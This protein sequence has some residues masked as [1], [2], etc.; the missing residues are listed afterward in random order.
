MKENEKDAEIENEELKNIISA[1]D[2]V[3]ENTALL[4]NIKSETELE[5]VM[6]VLL[7]SLGKYAGADRSYIFELKPDSTKILHMTHV[8][9]ADGISP[10]FR[11][12]QDLPLSTVPN[13]FSI[14]NTDGAVVIY[15]WD[16]D[17]EKWPEEYQLFSGQGIKS[18][19]I[20]PLVSGGSVTGYMGVDNPERNR[21]ELSVSLL[22]GI[23]GHISGL[24]ENLYMMKRLEENQLSLQKSLDEL[25]KE[26]VI[27]NALSVDYTSIYYCD[28]INDTLIPVKCE[29]Y[30]NTAAIVKK[31][32]RE[33]GS[34]SSIIQ[35][36]FG[37]FVIK[38][39]A[40]DFLEKMDT[41]YL[42][43]Y[44]SR[45]KRFAY[46]Y[47]VHPNKAGQQYFEVQ[48]VRLA[49]EDGF[50]VIMGYRYIDDLVAA[51]EKMQT[52]L[53]NALAEATLNSE[54]IGSI[55]KLYW[56]IY[57]VDLVQKTYEE[58]SAT[59]E[60]HKLTGKK[61]YIADILQGIYNTIVSEEYQPM[62]QEFLDMSTLPDRLKDTD[63]VVAEYKT[64]TGSWNMARIIAKKRDN[65]GN[66]LNALY[67]VRKIDQE[68]RKEI[69]YKQKLLETA[70]EARRANMA[71]TDF[72]RR[73]SHDIRTPINGI[74]GM[75][76]IAEHFPDDFAKQN[77]CRE[78]VKEASGFLLELV[79]NILDMNKLESGKIVLEHRPFDLLEVLQE[80]NNIA[81]INADLHGIQVSVDHTKIKHS[82]LIGSPIHLKQILQN[83][84]SNAVKYNRKGGSVSF[85]AT[86]IACA[87]GMVTYQ[88][89]CT[90]TGC[91]MSQ[92]FLSHAFEPF[93][94]EDTS[95][96]T[97]YMGTGLGLSIVKQLVEMM[98]GTIAVQSEQNVGTTF[99]ITIPFEIDTE[100]RNSAVIEQS[101][102]EKDLS[103]TRV[104]LVE[105]NEL[106]MEI[107][108]FI[109][110]NAGME[111]MTAFNGKEAVDIFTSS[112]KGQF[113]LILMDI[114][115]PVMDGLTATRTIRAMERKDARE[116]P[117]FAMTAN[118]FLDDIEESHKAGMNEHL[119]KPLDEKQMMNVIKRYVAA[120]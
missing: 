15:D 19:I 64:R 62:M 82:H 78:K 5:Q 56:L 27:L 96:R 80:I 110:E 61:G 66:V 24:K 102:S 42:R 6:P 86:E 53:E 114:M 69:A 34:Y 17:E 29:A 36:Y 43:E 95:A 111:V 67:V 88:F 45:H 8:W 52:Q 49:E 104:L 7:A 25:N 22:R 58:V 98:G 116:I 47:R 76:A 85:S 57:R 87:G 105:D 40:P 39:S 31:K 18:I 55:S 3:M 108:K 60:T 32:A 21:M 92:E 90:D 10:T 112:E 41:K 74:R 14:L 2:E 59:Q 48:I 84:D 23:S 12:M 9:C 71:K 100:Y 107:A 26:K 101:V 113:D 75:I 37:H 38:E 70:E 72:L 44:L 93:S 99:T 94:Q 120:N 79:N 20:I 106:N 33:N 91:G 16:A 46:K 117:I 63:S 1:V 68:K 30:N 13:W 11:E 28:L 51:Q 54:I 4:D 50:K 35:D 115:M 97:T 81:R 77:E 119:S 89:V 109:L 65:E 83:I 73:M 103:G 118:A